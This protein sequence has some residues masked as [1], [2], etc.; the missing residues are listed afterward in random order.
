MVFST[1]PCTYQFSKSYCLLVRNMVQGT[2]GGTQMEVGVWGY[3]GVTGQGKFKA[4][5]GWLNKSITKPVFSGQSQ[6]NTRT[7]RW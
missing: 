5:R 7:T 2:D 6:N 1:S 4:W 3:G